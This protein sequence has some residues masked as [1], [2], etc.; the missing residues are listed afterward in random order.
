MKNSH[1]HQ[2]TSWNDEDC[3]QFCFVMDD[4]NTFF[5]YCLFTCWTNAKLY[6]LITC[7]SLGLS[8]LWLWNNKQLLKFRAS[9]QLFP[10]LNYLLIIPSI[11]C[12][13]F[14]MS[15]NS[16]K[17]AQSDAF[18]LLVLFDQQS[19]SQTY[20]VSSHMWCRKPSNHHIWESGARKHCLIFLERRLKPLIEHQNRCWFISVDWLM[21][22]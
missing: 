6:V 3:Q 15:E 16:S 12:F 19:K 4:N 2:H 20:S 1:H 21:D 8:R 7:R 13:V 22:S 14:K 18:R 10:L 9:A 5:K 11:N 17:K